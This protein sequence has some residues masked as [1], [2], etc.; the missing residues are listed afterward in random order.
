GTS[1]E[2]QRFDLDRGMVWPCFVDMHTHLDKGHISPRRRNADGTFASALAAVQAD[3]EAN[4][5]AED[6][7]RRMDF[8]L[9][10]AWAHGTAVLRTHL[11]SIA[12]Q[13]TISWPVFAEMRERWAGRI[14]L[15]AVS[16]FPIELFLDKAFADDI[17]ATVKRH[18]GVLGAVT[19]GIPELDRGIELV[20]H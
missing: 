14:D 15:Q 12:P 4:W 1:A 2:Q 18:K 6:V 16:L 10:C 7:R 17:V 13:H 11:D 3:R 20:M 19:Y 9:R 8:S 5:S